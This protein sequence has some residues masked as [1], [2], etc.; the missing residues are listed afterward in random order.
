MSSV[1]QNNVATVVALYW[2]VSIS[3]VY[4]NKVLLSNSNASI[5]NAP[6]FLT[7]F[8]CFITTLICKGLGIINNRSKDYH[9]I[10]KTTPSKSFT[11]DD[12]SKRDPDLLA[13]LLREYPPVSYDYKT[14]IQILPLT[15]IFVLMITLNN[16][17]LEHVEVSFYNIARSLSL[18]FNVIFT[19]L[20]LNK[21]TSIVT[22]GTLLIVIVGFLLGIDGE[23]N[24]SL[25]GTIAGVM[26]SV[27]VSLN[28]IYTSKLLPRVNND[29]S[30]L[31][32]YNN[33]NATLMFIP[34]IIVYESATIVSNYERFFSLLFW[35][36][37]LLSGLFGFAIGLVTVMQ[38]KATSPLTH[39][40]S[41]TAK[42]AVQ[43]LFAFY[44]WGNS[45]SWKGLLGLCLV[46]CGSMLYAFVQMREDERKAVIAN[47]VRK[48]LQ[49]DN[50]TSCSSG[51][52]IEEKTSLLLND[53]SSGDRYRGTE[54]DVEKSEIS[55]TTF[56]DGINGAQN[57]I[58]KFHKGLPTLKI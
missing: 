43:S 53:S 46:L 47:S 2:A 30:V 56:N 4:L 22:I 21:S 23:M 1:D 52:D 5:A 8:Q 35:M 33:Y 44:L 39:N 9:I 58:L 55:S 40:I 13:S 12:S 20:L 27:F 11:E 28:S 19:Y 17:C 48:S 14:G 34:L 37:M 50:N 54:T 31:L 6:M 29:K 51:N 57:Y 36:T 26:S 38:V 42:A 18:V 41:G 49:A 32:F 16:I 3:M 25:F 24:F 15:T 45:Y 10:S 7:W